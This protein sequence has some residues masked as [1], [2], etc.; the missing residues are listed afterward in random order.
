M[1][2]REINEFNLFPRRTFIRRFLA[3]SALVLAGC[4]SEKAEDL[5]PDRQQ[6]TRLNELE[7]GEFNVSP[8]EKINQQYIT[9]L[10]DE[11]QQERGNGQERIEALTSSLRRITTTFVGEATV[12]EIDESG[13]YLT[14]KHVLSDNKN[15]FTVIKNPYT[16]ESS[17]VVDHVMTPNADLAIV[18]APTGKPKKPTQHLQVN[19]ENVKDDQELWMIG[20]FR[21]NNDLYQYYQHGRIDKSVRLA[22]RMDQDASLRA[23]PDA[24]VAVKDMI[25][26]GGTS[27]SPI[28]NRDGIVVAIESGFY[29]IPSNSRNDYKGAIVAPL[30]YIHGIA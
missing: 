12:F 16:G 14:A 11:L 29:P 2:N 8:M 25:P 19:L 4:S 3:G 1:S 23:E 6:L 22:S 28:V 5:L 21:Q 13:Y 15:V 17:V 26:A 18:Y 27:G 10:F 20:L 24:M 9:V 7:N 30:G